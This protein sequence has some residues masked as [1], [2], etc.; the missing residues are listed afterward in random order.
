MAGHHEQFATIMVHTMPIPQF[1]SELRSLVGDRPLWLACAG[2]VVLD[3]HERVLLMRRADTGRWA[4]PGGIIEPGEQPA[5]AAVRE[6][7]EETGVIVTPDALTSVSVSGQV[8]CPNGDQVQYL[9]LS[10][11]CQM[12]GGTARVNDD[13]SL[14]VGWHRPDALPQLDE[15]IDNRIIAAL[16][17]DGACQFGFSGQ[18]EATGLARGTAGRDPGNLG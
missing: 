10:F 3:D 7:Y 11:R 17:G 12:V 5:H 18:T 6:C 8:T 15:G 2:A 16:R 14:D 9:E 1:V 4:T 13:E